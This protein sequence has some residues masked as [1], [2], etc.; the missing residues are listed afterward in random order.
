MSDIVLQDPVPMKKTREGFGHALVDLGEKDSRIVVMVGD[1]TESTMVSFFAEKFPD[2]F[3]EI[4]IA[5][6]NM[7]SIAAATCPMAAT[8]PSMPRTRHCV[9]PS[10]RRPREPRSVVMTGRPAEKK[11]SILSF[12]PEPCSIGLSA[13]SADSRHRLRVTSSTSP[14]KST[15]GGLSRGSNA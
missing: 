10:R 7:A 3:F 4:G 15:L 12:V 5:E 11:S 6:Q 2:R 9:S 13:T 1:L 14:M 8:K